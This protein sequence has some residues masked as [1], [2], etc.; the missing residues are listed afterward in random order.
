[1]SR[2]FAALFVLLAALNC[3]GATNRGTSQPVIRN[4]ETGSAVVRAQILLGRANFSVGEIDGATGDNFRHA[5]T[6]FQKAHGLPVTGKVD[7]ATWKLLLAAPAAPE[8]PP[9]KK[10]EK[11]EG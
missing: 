6:G 5:V 8:G 3:P 4:T 1:M 10:T 9:S 11:T 2:T 7:P